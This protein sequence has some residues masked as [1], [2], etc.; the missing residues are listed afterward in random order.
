M[1][2]E[3]RHELA[4]NDLEK[5]G[6]KLYEQY[7]TYMEENGNRVLLYA[8]VGMLTVA[9][10]VWYV[11]SS[12]A[13][14]AEGW[15]QLSAVSSAEDLA[16]VAESFPGTQVAEWATLQKAEANLRNATGLMFT[17]REPGVKELDEAQKGFEKLTGDS[18]LPDEIKARA[19]FGLARTY[20]TG[21]DG[22]LS[23]AETQYKK[24]MDQFPDSL[25]A[26]LAKK[27]LEALKRSGSSEFYAWFKQQNPKPTDRKGPNDGLPSNI[28]GGNL[29]LPNA[30]GLGGTDSPGFGTTP[31]LPGFGESEQ[32]DPSIPPAPEM[33]KDPETEELEP[34]PT[35]DQVNES[36]E[37]AE[38]SPE[39]KSE[40]DTSESSDEKPS[41]A[42][43]S[44]EEA[45]AAEKDKTP[46][47]EESKESNEEGGATK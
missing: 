26:E 32:D 8:C 19:F 21:S 33:P 14:N 6:K 1:D 39:T 44:K 3:H 23:K 22:D 5:Y 31:I 36:K 46:A 10:L 43:E 37:K 15:A 29:G 28:P 4:Q 30:P 11:R 20:E 47:S 18:G 2:S 42:E 24:V 12:R 9:V 34:F 13:T 41:P 16:S 25:Q 40:A 38:P 45:S 17:N 27:R 35:K 7:N